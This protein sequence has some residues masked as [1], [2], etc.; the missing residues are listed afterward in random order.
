M[1]TLYISAMVLHTSGWVN[2][3]GDEVIEARTLHTETA[4]MFLIDTINRMQR[5]IF[6]AN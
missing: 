5:A 3:L 2:S 1:A 6:H 4:P